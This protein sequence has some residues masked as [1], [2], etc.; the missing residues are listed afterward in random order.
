MVTRGLLCV[1]GSGMTWPNDTTLIG[2]VASGTGHV[3]QIDVAN[4]RVANGNVPA[5]KTGVYS[6]NGTYASRTGTT[7]AYVQRADGTGAKHRFTYTVPAGYQGEGWLVTSVSG[8]GHYVAV[9]LTP[10]DP[11]RVTSGA[12]VIDVTTGK[13][14]TLPVTGTV[15]LVEF[16]SDGTAIVYTKTECV[17][18]DS[19][20][21]KI[22]SEQSDLAAH[23]G[24]WLTHIPQ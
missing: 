7:G 18:L 10:N 19:S 12:T 16:L 22:A 6:A 17:V 15:Q 24:S 2:P 9:G 8:D 20:L 4:A 13:Q 11:S 21:H 14:V 5:D 1:G 3:L 23:L